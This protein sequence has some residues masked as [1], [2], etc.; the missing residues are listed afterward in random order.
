M[1]QI[2]SKEIITQKR[3]IGLFEK[4]LKYAN[5]GDWTD[6]DNS[7]IEEAYLRKYLKSTQ[8]YSS[9]EISSAISQL[10]RAAVILHL[11]CI[12]PTKKCMVCFV[13]ESMSAAKHPKIKSTFT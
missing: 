6:R 3:I 10:K 12:M 8:Q 7:N 5:L 13:T 9:T 1:E 4:L 2:G 11:G